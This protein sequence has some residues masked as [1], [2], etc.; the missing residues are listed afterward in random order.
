MK[1]TKL[2]KMTKAPLNNVICIILVLIPI[3]LLIISK[4]LDLSGNFVVGISL[5][6]ILL[7]YGMIFG[8]ANILMYKRMWN[9]N[10]Y[11]TCKCGNDERKYGGRVSPTGI[12][13]CEV[14]HRKGES[15]RLKNK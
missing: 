5:V 2:L 10:K 4:P 8:K 3:L 12:F 14:C 1:I 11:F 9:G 13:T 15:I 7:L 6:C